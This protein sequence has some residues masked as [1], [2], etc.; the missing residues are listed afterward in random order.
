MP[1]EK[2]ETQVDFPALE[3]A[4]PR[5]SGTRSPPSTSS[6]ARTPA[7]RSGRSSTGRSPPTTR[8]ASTTP[9]AAPTRTPT[10]ATSPCPATSCA[11]RTASTARGCGSRSRSR[12]NWSS[13]ASGTSRTGARRRRRGIDRFVQRVQEARRT[14][15]PACR[16]SSRSASATGWT[17]TAPTRTG[18]SRRTSGKS[19]FT[20]SEENNYTIWTF[21]KKCHD[22]GLVYRGYDVDALVRP[23]RRRHLPEGDE[24]G[25]QA[26]RAP[27]GLRKLPLQGPARR[28]PPRLDD[29]ALDPDQQRRRRGQ[30]GADLPE[31]SAEGSGLLPRQGSLQAEPH[32]V[33]RRRRGR[34]RAGGVSDRWQEI[35]S[36][37][38]RRCPAP[39]HHRADVQVEGGQ[40]GLRLE[41]L[42]DGVQVRDTV[43]PFA[44]ATSCPGR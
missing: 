17:G 3:R 11:T 37:V 41:H 7:G 18:R 38:A 1:F 26:R 42:L 25:L 40:R 9:G 36:R 16:R 13:R 14:S 44:T 23:V 12:R 2:V 43:E 10:S 35:A 5:S 27:G 21:L 39:E 30:P 22:R 4:G 19:Y 32:G 24:R 29:D 28:E 31:G 34:R 15:S 20:M 33:R 6:G 8:W